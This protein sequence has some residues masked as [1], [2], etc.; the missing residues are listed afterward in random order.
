MLDAS[1]P[2]V[3]KVEVAS[4]EWTPEFVSF[5]N[6]SNSQSPV[7]VPYLNGPTKS[8]G[9]AIPL[10]SSAQS[11]TLTWNNIDQI[12]I[13]FNTD[14][15][16]FKNQL[17]L[18]GVSVQQYSFQAFHYE[19]ISHTATWTLTAPI[20]NDRIR[21]DLDG[22]GMTPV[23][24]LE[25]N[26][27]D[28]E[29]TDNS[30][31]VSGNGIPGGDFEFTFNVLPTDVNHSSSITSADYDQIYQLDGKT[32]LDQGYIAQ[33]DING[34][35]VIDSDDWQEAIDRAFQTLP[36][37]TPAGANNDAPNTGGLGILNISNDIF[38]Y[39][40][41]LSRYFT[42]QENGGTGLTY[43]IVS[44][45][46]AS[47]FDTV[48]ITSS[49]SLVVNAASNVSGRG[50]VTIR[51]TDT[52]GLSVDETITI[53]V[54]RQNLAPQICDYVI[55]YYENDI[56]IVSGR[57]VDGDDDVSNSLVSFW[58]VFSTRAAVDEQGNFLFAV[59][60]PDDPWGLEYAVTADVHAASSIVDWAPINMT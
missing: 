7:S 27:L 14:V 59:Y 1:L 49:K 22:N 17:S 19:P 35:A 38:N 42:D 11:T 12:I 20:S 25:W 10:G 26:T 24:D 41:R 50:S 44:I 37:G 8:H 56:Y 46:N 43:S 55:S 40:T 58:G 13:S 51:A 16:V 32:T 5:L 39:T 30:S 3:T 18:T 9:Y 53:D 6:P 36:T 60:L 15:N 31:L 52:T 2:S 23:M 29:W 21:I 28:G 48:T 33:R 4:T 47:L 45:D 57:V 54:N 34:D